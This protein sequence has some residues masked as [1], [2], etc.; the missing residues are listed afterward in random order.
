L[1]IHL[2][3]EKK[4]TNFRKTLELDVKV[5]EVDIDFQIDSTYNSKVLQD[6]QED[7]EEDIEL[8]G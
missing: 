8:D 5:H 7:F 3:S 1:E 6:E 2:F 4:S